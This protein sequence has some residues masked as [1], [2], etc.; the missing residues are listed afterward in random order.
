MPPT[1]KSPSIY[2]QNPSIDSNFRLLEK[3]KNCIII[4]HPSQFIPRYAWDQESLKNI[5]LLNYS[6]T[7]LS[8]ALGIAEGY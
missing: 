1:V 7:E 6:V 4:I 3:K 5:R 8:D 2:P